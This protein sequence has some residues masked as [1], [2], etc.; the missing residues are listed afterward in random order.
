MSLR[1]RIT[2]SSANVDVNVRTV[3]LR[4]D[5]RTPNFN[6]GVD[7]IQEQRE[8]RGALAQFPWAPLHMVHSVLV[9]VPLSNIDTATPGKLL[10]EL[11]IQAF[12]RED[13]VTLIGP[14]AVR[15]FHGTILLGRRP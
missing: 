11:E 2:D 5:P 13:E 14:A 15:P 12:E 8:L 6:D 10:F 9:E 7:D 1:L 4:G 3:V